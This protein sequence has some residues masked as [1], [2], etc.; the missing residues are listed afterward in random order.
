LHAAGRANPFVKMR[1]QFVIRNFGQILR[2]DAAQLVQRRLIEASAQVGHNVVR[3]DEHQL[4]EG[5]LARRAQQE[6]AEILGEA[7]LGGLVRV[8]TRLGAMA[9]H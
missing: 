8:A 1:L 4:V 5:V 6:R 9:R 3:R 2:K 7:I